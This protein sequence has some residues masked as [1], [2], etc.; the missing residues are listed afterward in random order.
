MTEQTVFTF[1][2][3]AGDYLTASEAEAWLCKVVLN[4]QLAEQFWDELFKIDQ[5]GL[6][7]LALIVNPLLR[8]KL[9]D[10]LDD[11][12]KFYFV[13]FDRPVTDRAELVRRVVH[14]VVSENY[15]EPG[16]MT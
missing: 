10:T 9:W 14:D 2:N 16:S 12:T 13:V 15:H 8:Q 11:D 7:C 5:G 6:W 3:D 4:P 1:T